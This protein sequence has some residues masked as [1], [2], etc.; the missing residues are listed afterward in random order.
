MT[1]NYVMYTMYVFKY[2]HSPIQYYIVHMCTCTCTQFQAY[3]CKAIREEVY[4]T[5]T[6]LLS[7]L[8]HMQYMF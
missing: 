7:A 3:Y 2:M 8:I 5:C 1:M 4:C 6:Q